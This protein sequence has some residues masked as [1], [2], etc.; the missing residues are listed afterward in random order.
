MNLSGLL[1]NMALTTGKIV[2]TLSLKL[3]FYF[4][5]LALRKTNIS[6]NFYPS[7]Q[8]PPPP[9]PWKIVANRFECNPENLTTLI[10]GGV[11]DASHHC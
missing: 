7:P 11:R 3:H 10:R 2:E 8:P 4:K 9:T 5:N 6:K 1:Q